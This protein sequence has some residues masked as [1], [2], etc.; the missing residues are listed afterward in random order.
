MHKQQ[1]EVREWLELPQSTRVKL[2]SDF[3]LTRSGNTEVA[4]HVVLTDGYL[5]TDLSRIS[6]AL[7]ESKLGLIDSGLDFYT[8]FGKLLNVYEGKTE[9]PIQ[10]GS[11]KTTEEN[12]GDEK[13]ESVHEGSVL[14]DVVEKP[15][16]RRGRPATL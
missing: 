14:P 15:K 10:G 1:L 4:D 8:L 16:K 3:N 7:I 12:R 9:E 13:I 5:Y 2:A 6:I 11:I